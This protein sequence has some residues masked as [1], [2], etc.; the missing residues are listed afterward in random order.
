MAGTSGTWLLSARAE[1]QQRDHIQLN[2]DGTRKAVV[3]T[4]I[5]S[6][7]PT[8]CVLDVSSLPAGGYPLNG[9]PA[10]EEIS[11]YSE[12]A[13]SSS[14]ND[15]HFLSDQTEKWNCN[16]LKTEGVRQASNRVNRVQLSEL[17]NNEDR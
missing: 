14:L 11:P 8:Q 5:L 1:R 10:T 6:F 4:M 17:E 7:I 15:G 13:A 3:E 9:C 12:N 16:M 2:F